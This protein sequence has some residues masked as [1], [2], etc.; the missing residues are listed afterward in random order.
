M[1]ITSFLASQGALSTYAYGGGQSK[2]F[3]GNP[4]ISLQLQCNPNISAHFIYINLYMDIK[5]S[6]TMQIEVRIASIECRNINITMYSIKKYHEHSFTFLWTQKYHF[7][8]HSDPKISDLPPRMCMCRV[9]PWAWRRFQIFEKAG[10]KFHELFLRTE[11][12]QENFS[13]FTIIPSPNFPE[14]FSI[15]IIRVFFILLKNSRKIEKTESH[16]SF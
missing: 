12:L 1:Y 5:Y 6:Q 10:V 15:F 14:I 13:N 8:Q 4:K 9:P 16:R 7:W 3:S 2:K 11:W